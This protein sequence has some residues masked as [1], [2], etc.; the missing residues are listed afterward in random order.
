MA[1]VI[2]LTLSIGWIAPE[3]GLRVVRWHVLLFDEPVDT[4]AHGECLH[5]LVH[6]NISA[7]LKR[8]ICSAIGISSGGGH[9]I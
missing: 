9:L 8:I 7:I 6:Q 5:V 4:K 3:K 2:N 1:H